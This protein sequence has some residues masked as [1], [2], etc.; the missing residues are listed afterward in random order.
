MEAAR[1]QMALDKPSFVEL[2]RRKMAFLAVTR[3]TRNPVMIRMRAH[4]IP[5]SQ[6]ES[7]GVVGRASRRDLNA[8]L[9][10]VGRATQEQSICKLTP[11]CLLVASLF[12]SSVAPACTQGRFLVWDIPKL[13]HL[14]HQI[15]ET[16]NNSDTGI[17]LIIILSR[18]FTASTQTVLGL[19]FEAT[20]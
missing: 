9:R 14:T 11:I 12:A 17:S 18:F 16:N 7:G 3:T 15:S 19:L 13:R 10:V 1:L 4:Q 20:C 2:S 6:R 5:R 8:A